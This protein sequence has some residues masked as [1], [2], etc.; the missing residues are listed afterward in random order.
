MAV[1]DH[2]TRINTSNLS[3]RSS[4]VLL[5]Y[6]VFAAIAIVASIY[7]ISGGLEVTE[8]DPSQLVGP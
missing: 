1:T 7:F 5:G 8:L 3:A 2:P 6:A 4:W